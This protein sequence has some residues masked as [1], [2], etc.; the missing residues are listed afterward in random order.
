MILLKDILQNY[1]LDLLLIQHT[2]DTPNPNAE[3]PSN[4]ELRGV[5]QKEPVFLLPN[6]E[7]NQFC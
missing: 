4:E 7:V 2:P 1:L 6:N 3:S 5:T